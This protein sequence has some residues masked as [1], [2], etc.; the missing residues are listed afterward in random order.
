MFM[1]VPRMT[2]IAL[3]RNPGILASGGNPASYVQAVGS[4][5]MPPVLPGWKPWSDLGLDGQ[6]LIP[7]ILDQQKSFAS[8]SN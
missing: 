7:E 2:G 1:L 5:N 6:G 8:F 4:G 3:S